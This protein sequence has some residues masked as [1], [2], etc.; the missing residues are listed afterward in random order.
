MVG[1]VSDLLTGGRRQK[2]KP[3]KAVMMQAP[4]RVGCL[5]QAAQ[6]VIKGA[7]KVVFVQGAK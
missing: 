6:K 5:R 3:W 2:R 1:L 4:V 7:Y